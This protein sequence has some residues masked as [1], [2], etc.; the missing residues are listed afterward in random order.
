MRHDLYIK[1]M[2][3]ELFD[4]EI[5][6]PKEGFAFMASLLNKQV[7][8][9][10]E[11]WTVF[12]NK[13]V[14]QPSLKLDKAIDLHFDTMQLAMQELCEDYHDEDEAIEQLLLF[15][16]GH[17]KRRVDFLRS[18]DVDAEYEDVGVANAEVLREEFGE[19][20][21]DPA[22][23][24]YLAYTSNF[25]QDMEAMRESAMESYFESPSYK[26]MARV[27]VVGKHAIDV[28]K[29]GVGVVGGILLAKKAKL[30]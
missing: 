14:G 26:R 28:A 1:Y 22:E 16:Y 25:N 29:V 30:L 10:Q 8:A 23:L 7:D 17:E 24:V 19:D 18:L 9:L 3:N 27:K 4:A 12:A 11:L 2:N 13:P 20:I 6:Q 15:T 5:E 21:I